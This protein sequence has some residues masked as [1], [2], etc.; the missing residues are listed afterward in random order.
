MFIEDAT[1][2]ELIFV[3]RTARRLHTTA[4]AYPSPFRFMLAVVEAGA[5][6]IVTKK[7]SLAAAAGDPKQLFT[8]FL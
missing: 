4:A 1:T 3:Y 5:R 2:S 6:P 8:H 7:V